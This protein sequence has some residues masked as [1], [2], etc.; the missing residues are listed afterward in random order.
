MYLVKH[1]KLDTLRVAKVIKKADGITERIISEANLLKNLKH[2]NIPIIYDIEDYNDSIC[3]IEEFIDGKDLC[4]YISEQ[5]NLHNYLEQTLICRIAIELCKVL[6]YLHNSSGILHMDIKPEN[7]II[8]NKGKVMLIDFDNAV[9]CRAGIAIEEGSLLYAAPEQ[10]EKEIAV[11]QS[12]VYAVGM[13]ILFMASGGTIEKRNNLSHNLELIKEKYP[14]LYHVVKK[15]T[16][17]NFLM[18]Y[19]GVTSIQKELE[20]IINKNDGVYKE[21]SYLIYVAGVR[22]GVGTTHVALCM[23]HFFERIGHR[24]IVIDRSGNEHLLMEALKGKLDSDG[25]YNC[26][27]I[28]ILPDYKGNIQVDCSKADVII[29]DGGCEICDN[30]EED[31][32]IVLGN[33]IVTRFMC[34]VV[35]NYIN[36]DEEKRILKHN[37]VVMANLVGADTFYKLSNN[38]QLGK[39]FYRMPCIYEW[40]NANPI[41]DETML[42]FLQDNLPY[43]WRNYKLRGIK[44]KNKR[45]RERI[46]DVRFIQKEKKKV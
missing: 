24:C 5:A 33:R 41:F 43:I 39:I 14:K 19:S 23:A 22:S 18:R 16:R 29:V 12:D 31:T 35:G 37:G 30:Y 20:I 8:D 13:V 27:N 36:R 10:Y 11:K 3:I 17:H 21:Q 45:M 32:S 4:E 34:L 9:N 40:Y 26:N 28:Q 42:D 44:V 15:C 7:I 6:E 2:P 46:M 25:M 38:K 1:K